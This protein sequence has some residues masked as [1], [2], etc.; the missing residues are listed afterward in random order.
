MTKYLPPRHHHAWLPF[1]LWAL[2]LCFPDAAYPQAKGYYRYPALHK[3]LIVF[4][5]EGDLWTVPLQGGAATRLTTH[6]GEETHPVISPDGKQVAFTANYEGVPEVYT[7]HLSGGLPKRWTY[8]SE[9][10]TATTWT[11]GGD[12]VYTT[13][14]Y[15]TL[16]NL[17]LVRIGPSGKHVQVPLAEASEGTF[18][19]SG[20]TVF[21]VRPSDHRNVTKRYKG[22]TA[23]RIW[24]YTEGTDEAI[25]LSDGYRGE[26][27]HPMWWNGRVY[28][29]T[30]R[31]SIM[32]IWSMDGNGKDLRQH[33]K[34]TVHDVRSASLY[35]GKIV[36]HAGADLWEHDLSTGKDTLIPITLVSDFD[37]LREKWVK[38]PQQY[39]T[40]VHL[41]AKGEKIVITAR[42]R[43]FVAPARD[44]RFVQLSRKE[45]VRYRDAVF[46]PTG[47]E[48]I[49]LLDEAGEF[50][51]VQ[52]A[53]T[54]TDTGKMLTHDGKTLRFA[55]SPSPDGKWMAYYD[56]NNDMWLFNTETK[57]QKLVSTNREGIQDISWSPDSR[58]VA[59]VQNALNSFAQIHLYEV[60]TGADIALT[61]DRA[62]STDPSWSPDGKWVYFLSD[63]NFE[64]V[65]GSPWGPR[66][67]EPYF[68]KQMKI[69]HIA[70]QKGTR[71]PFQPD[72][73]LTN[74]PKEDKKDGPVTVGIDPEGI[75]LRIKE[76]PVKPGNYSHLAV[77]GKSLYFISEETG[78][79]AKSHL[80]A[81]PIDNKEPKPV[82]LVEDI[83]GFELSGDGKK[84]LVRKG[85]GY[86]VVEAGTVAIGKLADNEVDLKGWSFSLNPREDFKQMFKD[87]WRMERDYFYDPGM[88]GVDWAAAY[89]KYLPLVERVTTRE[90]LSDIIGHYVGELEALHTS[91]RGGD[92]REGP[93]NIEIAGLGV[94]ATR[95]ESKNGYVIDYIYQ[96]DPDYPD[97]ISPLADPYLSVHPGDV[98]THINGEPTLSHTGMG[99]L[100][101][102][103]AGKQVRLGITGNGAARDV[104]VVPTDNEPSLRYSDWEYGRRMEVEKKGNGKIGYV[105]LRAMGSNDISQWYREFY[106]VFNRQG[107]IIDA[108]TNRGGNIDSFILEK[109]M[110][111]A[112]FYFSP[113]A[114]NPTW[115]MQYAFRGHMVVLV[116]Q[117]TASDGEAFAEGFRRLGLGKV[118]GMRTWG[119]E[120]WLGSQNRLSDGGLARAPMTGVYGPE[121]KW[122]IEGHGV[123][124][125]IEVDNLPHATFLG[126]DAQLDAAIQHLQALMRED[127]REVPAPPPFPDKAYKP[128]E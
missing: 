43:V 12:I 89:N 29:I 3:D 104:I 68:D 70:L 28:F 113:R 22:G 32:N 110:R 47:K 20:K 128:K 8:E 108:R 7:M 34:Q 73:E 58:W 56:L 40:S 19:A 77:N 59:F 50:E 96:A 103:Q 11:P 51:F 44:G 126:K 75:R 76:V 52:M 81:L 115:N 98:I 86:Y 65:V 46:H 23:R 74:A 101:R 55:A 85:K 10:S 53:A 121:R 111:K 66:Q 37:Q 95:D 100:L 54:G 35:D 57:K 15:S 91:V 13:S 5:A 112:W 27:H 41:D 105:H 38:D 83:R 109:L 48:V 82:T 69:Y 18:D 99:A 14:H 31:D 6:P 92:M 49:A 116:N 123:V 21:F 84:L 94:R 72:D 26:S 117:N 61:T 36:Y 71:S 114:G 2:L 93:D 60:A 106:P 25:E 33:T 17:Q 16:P 64:S 1:A 119:G 122:L 67:P 87:A 4:V 24:K 9:A 39:I 120:I 78:L 90:E 80:M 30:D 125:D 42:G 127:P 107:L 79:D 45:G 62:N 124:P 63:R 118:I 102:N 97:K 88:H